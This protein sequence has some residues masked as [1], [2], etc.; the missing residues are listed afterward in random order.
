[1]YV[2]V[3]LLVK[4]YYLF[5]PHSFFLSF[6]LNLSFSPSFF[7][8]STGF[9]AIAED[10]IEDD[11][12]AALL[13]RA[14]K[15]ATLPPFEIA[16]PLAILVASEKRTVRVGK[17]ERE[18]EEEEEKSR[19]T[20]SSSSLSPSLPPSLLSLSP[21]R[22]GALCQPRHQGWQR[23]C[24][25]PRG[26]SYAGSAASLPWG[27]RVGSRVVY[28]RHKAMHR[29]EVKLREGKKRGREREREREKRKKKK[30]KKKD[31]K[32]RG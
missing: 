5:L 4:W 14:L 24:V 6:F 9:S 30:K 7:L 25:I 12:V 28:P 23:C 8:S 10:I 22:P 11:D 17:D 13:S 32:K 26:I 21:T 20:H 29:C 18:E 19:L 3:L 15:P 31:G 1:M 27:S 2:G 16:S